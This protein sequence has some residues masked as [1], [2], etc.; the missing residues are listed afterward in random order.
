M[1][2]SKETIQLV[3]L[4]F[5]AEAIRQIWGQ[6]NTSEISLLYLQFI[7]SIRFLKSFSLPSRR[8]KFSLLSTQSPLDP[9]FRLVIWVDVSPSWAKENL[10]L[11][12]F[13]QDP[14][15]SHFTSSLDFKAWKSTMNVWCS[16]RNGWWS[17]INADETV[18]SD[19]PMLESSES[20]WAEES[21]VFFRQKTG[22]SKL[23]S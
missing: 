6:I 9:A 2:S 13:F 22:R 7:V 15:S 20:T 1:S 5:R 23:P 11:L 4:T 8:K 18:L 10:E 14:A 19:W 16:T 3:K 21:T 12:L 17:H